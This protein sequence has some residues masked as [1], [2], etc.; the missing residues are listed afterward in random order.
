MVVEAAFWF[1]P[2][3]WWV[4][5]RL[6]EE[7]ERACDEHVLR[8]CGEPEAYA[9]SILNVCKFYV[10]SP[11]ACVSGVSGSDLK[12][13]IAAI[14]VNRV[15]LQLNLARKVTLAVA[16]VLAI[17]LPLAAG[18]LTAPLRASAFAAVQG[19]AAAPA[20]SQ[21]PRFEVASIKPC[22]PSAPWTARGDPPPA[23]FRRGG[24]PSQAYLSPG[25]A[26]WDRVTLAQLIDQAYADQDHSLLNIVDQP[27][28]A[29]FQPKRVRGGPSWVESDLFT[30]EA[31]ATVDVTNSG[32]AGRSSRYLATLPAAMSQAL[33][34]LLED[35]FK[36]KVHRA[37]EQQAM[38]ALTIAKGGLNKEKMIAPTPGDCLTPAEYSAAVA[39]GKVSPSKLPKVCGRV[40]SSLDNGME[41]SSF[42][43][44][45][46][47]E[48]MS[49]DMEHFVLD[50]T[51]VEA[52]FNFVLKPERGPGDVSLDFSRTLADLG[53]KLEPTKGPA[54]YLVIDR[55]ERPAPD[56]P[57][58]DSPPARAVGAGPR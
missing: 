12:K 9:E 32:L 31:K 41:F 52:T 34:A 40:F 33:R 18:M 46:L 51:G 13:R 22:D 16:A 21:A 11:L 54:E 28:Q 42:T 57:A 44:R 55:A 14:M 30:I 15:G 38:Y 29:L 37:T 5:A 7:R 56:S 17:A 2:L 26:Y 27:H 47:A 6:V 24:A 10:E 45:H 58:P 49:T 8:V 1:H 25:Y 19:A 20:Q 48:F 4:G 3:V 43:L 36:V 39:A 53:L 23:G 50:H 35:R